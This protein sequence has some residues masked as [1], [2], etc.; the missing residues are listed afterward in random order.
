VSAV[1]ARAELERRLDQIVDHRRRAG[2]V[3]SECGAVLPPSAEPKRFR[4]CPSTTT[5][6]RDLR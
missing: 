6:R 1:D 2:Q 4:R 3:C 5:A